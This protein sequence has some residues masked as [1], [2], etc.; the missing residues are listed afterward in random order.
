MFTLFVL[1]IAGALLV[2]CGGS[3]PEGVHGP[4]GVLGDST[5]GPDSQPSDMGE[6]VIQ[7]NNSGQLVTRSY[8]FEGFNAVEANFFDVDI[9]QGEDFAVT[10]ELEKNALD[11]V[12]VRVEDGRLTLGLNPSQ[13]YQMS[14]IPMRAEVTM[15]EL[16]ELDLSMSAESTIHGFESDG[17]LAITLNLSSSLTGDL[18]ARD[19]SFDLSTSSTLALSGSGRK[20]TIQASGGSE[21][22]LK[23]FHVDDAFV[24]SESSSQVTLNPNN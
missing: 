1:L 12:Q 17:D 13:T 19:V 23:D 24:E 20:A 15:P 2:G 21:V 10:I 11:Y 3:D 8:D 6:N 5:I 7:I 14:D 18:V 9:H 16:S 4:D 22:D